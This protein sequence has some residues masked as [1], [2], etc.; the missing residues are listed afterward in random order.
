MLKKL[1]FS[2]DSIPTI[3][4]DNISTTYLCQNPL[5]H[6]RIKQI[7]VDF[8]LRNQVQNKE[9]VVQHL[10]STNQVANVVTKL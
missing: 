10:H 8:H 4:C 2:L 3:Y 6:N 1:C 9:V 5:F 7:E